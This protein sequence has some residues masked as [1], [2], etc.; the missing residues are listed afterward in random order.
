MNLV[1]LRAAADSLL[2][3]LPQGLLVI[4]LA[5]ILVAITLVDTTLE[6]IIRA[7]TTLEQV[8]TQV[9]MSENMKGESFDN[10]SPT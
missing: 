10:S 3:N 2:L 7:D 4:A 8:P 5:T 6:G 9:L 1:L